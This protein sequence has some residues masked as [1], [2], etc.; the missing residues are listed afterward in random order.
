MLEHFDCLVLVTEQLA[1]LPA[2]PSPPGIA[3]SLDML[4]QVVQRLQ[5][6]LRILGTSTARS[7]QTPIGDILVHL[8]LDFRWAVLRDGVSALEEGVVKSGG[9]AL[10]NLENL[11]CSVRL[12]EEGVCEVC[13]S[14]VYPP[15]RLGS[16][17]TY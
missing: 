6:T 14:L 11:S 3:M 17:F 10:A 8:A 13:R 16:G 12:T 15:V 2:I 7:N 4:Q 5:P 9:H 1:T